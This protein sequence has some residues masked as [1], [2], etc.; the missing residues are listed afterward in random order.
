MIDIDDVIR[1]LAANAE[2]VRTMVEGLPEERALWRS[3][4]GKW[5]ILEVVNHL[6]DEEREDFRQRTDLTLHHPGEPWP[7]TDPE[8]WVTARDYQS[9]DLEESLRNFLDERKK[10][11]EWLRG[12]GP[13]DWDTAYIHPVV[14]ALSAG[15]LLLSWVAHDILHIRQMARILYEHLRHESAPYSLE[16]ADP[17]SWVA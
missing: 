12:L 8:G 4:P 16:Y 2:T 15:S 10:T 1:Q 13:T 5:S 17:A 3:A 11:L 14:G 7:R 6:Y 9:R